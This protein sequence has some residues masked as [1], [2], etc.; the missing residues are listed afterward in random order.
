MHPLLSL[1]PG[2]DWDPDHVLRYCPWGQNGERQVPSVW[3]CGKTAGALEPTWTTAWSFDSGIPRTEANRTFLHF[4]DG[5]ST[6]SS[7][8]DDETQEYH[9]WTFHPSGLAGIGPLSM[10]PRLISVSGHLEQIKDGTRLRTENEEVLLLHRETQGRCQFILMHASTGDEIEGDSL[11]NTLDFD[12]RSAAQRRFA[13]RMPFWELWPESQ[14]RSPVLF[15]AF[16]RMLF[17]LRNPIEDLSDL[18]MESSLGD[19]CVNDLASYVNTWALVDPDIAFRLIKTAL[20]AK[21]PDGRILARL[22]TRNTDRTR[23]T[24]WPTLCQCLHYLAPLLNDPERI[25]QLLPRIH[26]VLNR[27]YQYLDNQRDGFMYWQLSGEALVPDIQ[28]EDLAGVDGTALLLA[29]IEAYEKILSYLGMDEAVDHAQ[30]TQSR[31]TMEEHLHGFFFHPETLSYRDRYIG[32]K[33][34]SRIT[35]SSITPLFTSIPN[36]STRNALFQ[37]LSDPK[38]LRAPE[39]I[40]SWQPWEQDA[41]PAPVSL[42]LQ[43]LLTAAAQWAPENWQTALIRSWFTT[44]TGQVMQ[45]RTERSANEE[46]AIDPGLM[47]SWYIQLAVLRCKSA[48]RKE[49]A[50]WLQWLEK[51]RRWVV[52]IPVLSSMVLILGISL[53]YLN[54]AVPPR[55]TIETLLGLATQHYQTGNYSEALAILNDLTASHVNT[56]PIKKLTAHTLFRQNRFSEAEEIFHTLYQS[57]PNP[58]IGLNLGLTQ[59]RQGKLK[60]AEATYR[61]VAD[62]NIENAPRISERAEVCIELIH[63]GR[64]PLPLERDQ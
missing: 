27:T 10:R 31:M 49:Q 7:T 6:Q 32:G 57:Q 23:F 54:K 35:L 5:F 18:W 58:I 30:L 4:S 20:D 44:A 56:L 29:D 40:R 45:T 50:P 63:A 53:L 59:F 41:E 39:G 51:Q 1:L 64:P 11:R 42:Q 22:S 60:E 26:A 47:G 12:L 62:E 61:M 9:V 13:L 33:P 16:E 21:S 43:S 19:Y 2:A 46:H 34:I 15:R 3:T 28:D 48:A 17:A 25:H 52:G 38:I 14:E 8:Q 36:T 55:R 24:A 37:Q